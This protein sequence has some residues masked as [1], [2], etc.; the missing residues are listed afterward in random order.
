MACVLRL[1]A[2]IIERRPNRAVVLTS[3]LNRHF[4]QPSHFESYACKKQVKRKA[5]ATGASTAPR[6]FLSASRKSTLCSY[7]QFEGQVKGQRSPMAACILSAGGGPSYYRNHKSCSIA[8]HAIQNPISHHRP[9][10]VTFFCQR[11]MSLRSG[12]LVF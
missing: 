4:Q 8:G 6:T 3:D 9:L 1:N 7:L 5:P 10:P 11:K 2:I 12:S